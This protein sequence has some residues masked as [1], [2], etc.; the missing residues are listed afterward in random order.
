MA[1]PMGSLIVLYVSICCNVIGQSLAYTCEEKSSCRSNLTNEKHRTCWCDGKCIQ[2]G[3]CCHDYQ[4]TTEELTNFDKYKHKWTTLKSRVTCKY[5][6]PISNRPLYIVTDCPRDS[7]SSDVIR[8]R[9]ET[10]LNR[11]SVAFSKKLMMAKLRKLRKNPTGRS[12][13][14]VKTKRYEYLNY[15]P[16]SGLTGQV[17]YRNA[18]CALCNSEYRFVFFRLEIFSKRAFRADE[19]RNSSAIRIRLR[20]AQLHRKYRYRPPAGFPTRPCVPTVSECGST[21]DDDDTKRKCLGPTALV[22]DYLTGHVYRNVHCALCNWVNV[23]RLRCESR[24]LVSAKYPPPPKFP[25]PYAILIDLN[26]GILRPRSA[27]VGYVREPITTEERVFPVCRKITVPGTNLTTE[28]N[29]TGLVDDGSCDQLECPRGYI[30]VPNQEAVIGICARDPENGT[31]VFKFDVGLGYLTLVGNSLS[32]FGLVVLLSVYASVPCLRNTPGKC[33]MSLSLS[34]LVSQLLFTTAADQTDKKMLC[35]GVGVAEHYLFLVYAFWMSVMAFDVWRAFRLDSRNYRASAKSRSRT[36]ALY[37]AYAWLGPLPIVTSSVVADL[38]DLDLRPR[39]AEQF[40]WIGDRRALLWFFGLPLGG[41]VFAST[42]L[43]AVTL[44]NIRMTSEA[45]A[46]VRRPGDVTSHRRR[47]ALS[48]RLAVVT[49]VTWLAGF[50]A[51]LLDHVV[52]WYAFTLTNAF[53]GVYICVAFVFT[54]KVHANTIGRIRRLTS[55]RSRSCSGS[56][57]KDTADFRT[58]GNNK[59]RNKNEIA[60]N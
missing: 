51:T 3:D 9:C 24:Y 1:Y 40:C 48:V 28:V 20:E 12:K 25:L 10:S 60:N 16:V 2:Y 36:F 32:M 29:L 54:K 18:F 38:F 27:E 22:R 43:F 49:A 42:A 59:Y 17:V 26:S 30:Y 46:C 23:T 56:T 57:T 13:K 58:S 34:L 19:L 15:I 52:L 47:L 8:T 44:R 55:S 50:L 45:A 35:V 41:V 37:A 53:Q 33:L 39:Y 14:A 21:W 11:S 6:P 31:H 7:F 5:F 4:P